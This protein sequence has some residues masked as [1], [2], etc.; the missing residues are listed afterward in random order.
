MERMLSA[1]E[2]SRCFAGKHGI[3]LKNIRNKKNLGRTKIV[4]SIEEEKNSDPDH[5]TALVRKGVG[6]EEKQEWNEESSCARRFWWTD[7]GVNGIDTA[8]VV[9]QIEN[10]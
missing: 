6:D 8:C 7:D 4:W 10:R 9:G 2:P 5:R 1:C 3:L